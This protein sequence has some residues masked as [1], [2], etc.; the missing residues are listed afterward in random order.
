MPN[1]D[2]NGTGETGVGDNTDKEDRDEENKENEQQGKGEGYNQES[3]NSEDGQLV[4]PNSDID[5][6]DEVILCDPTL[7]SSLPP[8]LLPPNG[9]EVPMEVPTALPPT[10]YPHSR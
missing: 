4:P 2:E 6:P 5:L 10:A 7:S 8:A 9:L 3:E 1:T